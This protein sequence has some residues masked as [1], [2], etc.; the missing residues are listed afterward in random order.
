MERC[1]TQ[2][3]HPARMKHRE[4]AVL[5]RARLQLRPQVARARSSSIL[6]FLGVGQ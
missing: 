4:G 3:Q 6:G 1:G 2:G 5:F